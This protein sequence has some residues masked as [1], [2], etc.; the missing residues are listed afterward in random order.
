MKKRRN[1]HVIL[2]FLLSALISE[3]RRRSISNIVVAKVN[4][5]STIR[6]IR[7]YIIL[8]YDS[9]ALRDLLLIFIFIFTTLS[10]SIY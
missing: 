8:A 9:E 2:N 10:I 6:K 5:V 3:I 4:E 1:L 7:H